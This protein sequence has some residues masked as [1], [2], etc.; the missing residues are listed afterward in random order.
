MRCKFRTALLRSNARVELSFDDSGF[1][2]AIEAKRQSQ[3]LSWRQ[4]GRTLN[5]SPSTFSRLARGRRPDVE[6]FLRLLAWLQLPADSFMIGTTSSCVENAPD[7]LGVIAAALRAD[8][9]I[10]TEGAGALERLF[11]V[12]YSNLRTQDASPSRQ[13]K[14]G[15]SSRTKAR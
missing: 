12:A 15:G 7:T 8:R 4:L 9:S 10:P 11:R 5:L 6:T 14:P 1:Y 2:Q 13:G 3:G